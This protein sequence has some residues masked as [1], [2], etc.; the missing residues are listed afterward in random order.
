MLISASVR[1]VMGLYM[2]PDE[3]YAK[4]KGLV[5]HEHNLDSD[6]SACGSQKG[7]TSKAQAMTFVFGCKSTTCS[8]LGII[9]SERDGFSRGVSFFLTRKARV[10]TCGIQ[11]RFW[12]PGRSL[13]LHDR[14]RRVGRETLPTAAIC[15]LSTSRQLSVYFKDP[16]TH[17]TEQDAD[18]SRF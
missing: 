3:H 12:A 17:Q 2:Y 11:H 5:L 10:P 9:Y 15:S 16:P 14:L 18:T 8:A 13:H 7:H 4:F 1:M 6:S